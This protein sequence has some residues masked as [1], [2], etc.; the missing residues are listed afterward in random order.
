[1]VQS[2]F[3]RHCEPGFWGYPKY[4][5]FHS[6]HMWCKPGTEEDV[7]SGHNVGDQHCPGGTLRYPFIENS[8][9][10]MNI[11]GVV[12]STTCECDCGW[13]LGDSAKT[14]CNTSTCED[15][16]DWKTTCQGAPEFWQAKAKALP[17][18]ITPAHRSQGNTLDM[19]NTDLNDINQ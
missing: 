12:D 2:S 9:A 3:K 17:K 8:H 16:G 4:E 18:L 1:M 5:N 7:S 11:R 6:D 19:K 14:R 13:A 10:G 15:K